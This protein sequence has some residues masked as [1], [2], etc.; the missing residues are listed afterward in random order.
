MEYY[1]WAFYSDNIIRTLHHIEYFQ[2]QTCGIRINVLPS[3]CV[4]VPAELGP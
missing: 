3:A 2:V 1:G 4:R